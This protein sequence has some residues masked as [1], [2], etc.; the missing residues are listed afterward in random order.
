MAETVAP[1]STPQKLDDIM[2]AMD[3]VDTLRHRED[4]V[5]RELNEEGRETELIARLRKIYHDQGIEVP[6]HVLADGVKALKESRFTYTP[7]P[8]GLKR[9]LLTLWTKRASYGK[10]TGIAAAAL[11]ATYVGY[12]RM[13]AAP[14]RLV[15]EQARVEIAETLPRALRQTHADII[16]VAVGDVLAKQKAD[17]LL[18]DG[19]R[20][21]RDGNRDGV[22]AASAALV[23]LR[24]QLRA[25]QSAEQALRQ[26]HA[27]ALAA[28]VDNAAKQ[29][30]SA[31]LA[32]GE[33][34]ARAG[35]KTG[36]AKIAAD[37]QVLKF[38]LLR[39]YTLT[40]VSRPNEPSLVRRRPPRSTSADARNHYVIVEAIAPDG[41][42]LG[43]S[44][45]S[46]E[47]GSTKTVTK[48][49]MRV[50]QATYDAIA[51]DK[52]DDGII[53]RNRFGVKRRGML[54]VEYLMPFEGG[55]ITSW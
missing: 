3:V 53:Q 36:A 42:K 37:L 46:E 50:P 16:T 32:D 40:I 7:P 22:R 2:I 38:D 52:R 20:A 14:A 15:Q 6:D 19:E 34:L 31:L 12:D 26:A 55:Y 23:A 10:R 48:F 9:S 28:A 27:E 30:A 43:L 39:E 44:I 17:A 35:D 8:A 4:L 45:R 24:D 33:R 54:E 51:Q 1:P 41:N 18:A 11:L 25:A 21:L 47:D 29:K 5:R 49:G 13:V